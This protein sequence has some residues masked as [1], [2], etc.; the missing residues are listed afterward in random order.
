MPKFIYLSFLFGIIAIPEFSFGADKALSSDRPV[1][2]FTYTSE[3]CKKIKDAEELYRTA[4][5]LRDSKDEKERIDAVDC[6]MASASRGYGAA[7]F[8]VAKMYNTGTILPLSQAFAYRW[9]QLA[10]MDKYLDA[11]PLRDRLEEELSPEELESALESVKKVYQE[12][13]DAQTK[14]FDNQQGNPNDPYYQSRQN[15][16]PS[17]SYP[18]PYR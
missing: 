5:S 4:L 1:N 2:Y 9:A 3:Q 16:S 13:V 18:A 15:H 6:F 12:R 17:R 10:V 8:E 14:V 7:E 11:V